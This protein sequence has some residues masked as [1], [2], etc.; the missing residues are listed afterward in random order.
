MSLWEFSLLNVV[1]NSCVIESAE[2]LD[3]SDDDDEVKKTDGGGGGDGGW[4]VGKSQFVNGRRRCGKP[5]GI[6]SP[7]VTRTMVA[8]TVTCNIGHKHEHAGNCV[9]AI[10]KP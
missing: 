6:R 10:S 3:N 9:L 1:G 8:M 5:N 4:R 2:E 7:M